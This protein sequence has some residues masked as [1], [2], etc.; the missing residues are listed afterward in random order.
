MNYRGILGSSKISDIRERRGIRQVST[1]EE[2]SAVQKNA[3]NKRKS[4][5]QRT[6]RCIV[7]RQYN[8]VN[9]A[10]TIPYT[11]KPTHETLNRV[12]DTLDDA[13]FLTA[14]VRA[15]YEELPEPKPKKKTEKGNG[16][17]Q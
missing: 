5:H 15:M 1:T 10:N 4:I 16:K 6:H 2:S 7:R 14:L 17:K 8:Y 13:D 11:A 12:T 3:N 9:R